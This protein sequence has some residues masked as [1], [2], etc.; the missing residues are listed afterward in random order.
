MSGSD[1]SD[2]ADHEVYYLKIKVGQPA[3]TFRVK[4]DTSSY[5]LVLPIGTAAD[6]GDMHCMTCHHKNNP[7]RALDPPT[8]V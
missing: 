1:S 5:D 2:G 7:V 4:L 8:F 6:D 3:K